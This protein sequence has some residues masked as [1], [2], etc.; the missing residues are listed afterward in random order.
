VERSVYYYI[1]SSA[2]GGA[3]EA[4]LA[5][6]AH[7]DRGRWAPTLLH[8]DEPA[9]AELLERA[10]ALGMSRRVVPPLPLG[11]G[12][13]RNV[14]SFVR[15]LRRRP[16]DVFHAQLTWPLD[17]KWALLG[18]VAAGVSAVA[19]VQLFPEGVL[20]RSNRLQLA[21][22]G[23]RVDRWIAVSGD[24]AERL[25][26]TFRWPAPKIEVVRN[27]VA[28]APPRPR[29]ERLRRELGAVPGRPLVLLLARLEHQ[30]GIDVLLQ[31]AVD[32]DASFAVAGDGAERAE[33][34]RRAVELGVAD[35]VRFLGRRTDVPDLLAAADVFALP[36]R[37][38]GTSLALLEAMAAG[39]PV[40]A[41]AIGGNDEIVEDGR[42]GVLVPVE[43]PRALAQALRRLAAD[44]TESA[45]LGAAARARVSERFSWAAVA[46]RV[47]AIYEQVIRD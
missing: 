6:V 26:R 4:L 30:K 31:A 14:P 46:A 15:E 7:L 12:G 2:V 18:A 24:I 9:I 13:A 41:T 21:V 16:P 38:E 3:E 34:E 1:D 27:G 33:L 45:R 28:P 44:D 8:H 35:R 39:K 11:V 23:R 17:A 20:D 19:T 36:S 42:T 43:D 47:G 25:R 10:D 37:Y 29:D 5:L 40:V 32:V 22:L